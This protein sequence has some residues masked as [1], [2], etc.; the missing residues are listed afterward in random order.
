MA[1]DPLQRCR[2]YVPGLRSRPWWSARDVP[3]AAELEAHSDAIAREFGDLVLAGRL[4][5]HPESYGGPRPS[6]TDGDWN[7]F[8]LWTRGRPHLGNLVE[9]PV[10]AQVLDSMSNAIA[11]PR[12]NVFFSVLR[13]RVHVR[14]HCGPTNTRIRLHL[15][16]QVPP[17]AGMR[18]GTETRTWQE[19]RCLVF[20]DSWEHEATNPSDRSRSV[21]LVDIWHPD[22]TVQQRDELREAHADAN[23]GGRQ[24]GWLRPDREG[25]ADA[26]HHPGPIDPAIFGAL[27]RGRVARLAESARKARVFDLPF[28]ATAA[29]RL[30]R[31]LVGE[32]DNEASTD[33]RAAAMIEDEA[34]WAELVELAEAVD[35]DLRVSE[36]IDLVLICSVSW[37][38]WGV[39]AEAMTAFLDAWPPAEKAALADDLTA[40]GT[41]QPVLRALAE[42]HP[43]AGVP[44]FGALVPV[45]CAAHRRALTAAHA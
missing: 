34:I 26:A 8:E 28:V 15:G 40:L 24:R 6:L 27:D 11:M 23:A 12:G 36:L 20:D 3:E 13:P 31:V 43:S 39:R 32:G 18:V 1:R 16:I 29:R 4:R 30:L 38:S 19:G 44:P 2:H 37:R 41:V 5:L 10:T 9:A 33:W 35:H 42:Y 22:L 25:A 17:G 45:V 14:A 21:L 7:M